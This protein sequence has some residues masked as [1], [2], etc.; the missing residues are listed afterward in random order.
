MN[1]F[2]SK[3]EIFTKN[4]FL[5][6]EDFPIR[7]KINYNS[8]DNAVIFYVGETYNNQIDFY[9]NTAIVYENMNESIWNRIAF[10]IFCKFHSDKYKIE[11]SLKDIY[12]AEIINELQ[13]NL[14]NVLFPENFEKSLFWKSKVEVYEFNSIKLIYSKNGEILTEF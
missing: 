10:K 4:D 8:I 14:P 13:N 3:I 5:I 11:I 6:I 9:L 1:I 12:L 7:Q 2:N